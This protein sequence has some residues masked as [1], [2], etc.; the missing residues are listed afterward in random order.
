M[1]APKNWKESAKFN[2]D[3]MFLL[4]I[5][6]AADFIMSISIIGI[7]SAFFVLMC[8]L[9]L[10]SLILGLYTFAN[11]QLFLA[12]LGWIVL[13]ILK[14]V[15]YLF[16]IIL[17]IIFH[18]SI[19]LTSVWALT[20]GFCFFFSFLFIEISYSYYKHYSNEVT[21]ENYQQVMMEDIDGEIEEQ[22]NALE[23]E[24]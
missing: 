17:A 21:D 7:G 19:I 24:V 10:L 9:E 16:F 11:P 20:C 23:L 4:M 13:C 18:N 2:H 5:P 3:I 8:T 1:G 14:P 12:F 15:L 6:A 22:N